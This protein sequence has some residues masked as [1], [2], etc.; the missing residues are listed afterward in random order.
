MSKSKKLIELKIGDSVWMLRG[1]LEPEE[2]EVTLIS[3]QKIVISDYYETVL[4]P[5]D[6]TRFV[7]NGTKY[8]TQTFYTNKLMA[9]KKQREILDEKIIS[10]YKEQRSFI[11]RIISKNEEIR[12]C[13]ANIAETLLNQNL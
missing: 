12:K 4:L 8:G 11:E 6:Y 13:D 10:I 7:F 5:E 2:K 3:K 9:L 1:E